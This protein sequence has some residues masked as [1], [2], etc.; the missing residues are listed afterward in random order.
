MPSL[1]KTFI[2]ILI[3]PGFNE[4]LSGVEK[5]VIAQVNA[6]RSLGLNAHFESFTAEVKENSAYGTLGNINAVALPANVWF[7]N[8]RKFKIIWAKVDKIISKEPETIVYV[9]YPFADYYLL[10]LLKKYKRRIVFEHN[11]KEY[12]ELNIEIKRRRTQFK[13]I[14]SA[15][16]FLNKIDYVDLPNFSEKYLAPKLF[17]L[18]KAGIAVTNEI[19]EYEKTRCK[20]YNLLTLANGIEVNDYPLLQTPFFLQ[21]NT[22]R[23]I[24]LKGFEA[25]WH[26]VERLLK[27]LAGYYKQ[28]PKN[29][30]EIYIYGV[31]SAAEKEMVEQLKLESVV[32]FIEFKSKQ[33]LD[34]EFNN[35]HL[36]IGSLAMFKTNLKEAS[37]LKVREYMA[38]GIPFIYAYK[39]TDVEDEPELKPFCLELPSDDSPVNFDDVLKFAETVYGIADCNVLLKQKA[40]KYID[41]KVK[42][43][44]L[45]RF[46]S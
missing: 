23:L 34:K 19:A 18:A 40:Q 43:E 27:G 39:D 11:T 4:P 14:R 29:K 26:G 30:I 1:K 12:D 9:R 8:L 10:Q 33:E 32:F 2:Y 5:K 24:M 35:Y 6:I 17:K 28:L 38:R 41:V 36:A 15:G 46:L 31:Y 21:G 20:K 22:L 45:I 44:K 25:S 7:W 3:G 42:M 16:A 13:N 37:P